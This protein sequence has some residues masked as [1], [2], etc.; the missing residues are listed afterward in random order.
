MVRSVGKNVVERSGPR[1][2]DVDTKG[3]AHQERSPPR[4]AATAIG[5]R[6]VVRGAA[7]RRTAR[8][9][10]D[11][12]KTAHQLLRLSQA[13]TGVSPRSTDGES[14]SDWRLHDLRRT[15]RTNLS[16]LGVQPNVAELMIGHE[17]R[18]ILAIYDR[19]A[20]ETEQ[21]AGFEAWCRR[22]TTI[23]GG[24][25]YWRHGRQDTRARH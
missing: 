17:Q 22:L 4:R 6:D 19:H 8:V 16:V 2:G 21:R 12:W 25:Q 13:S 18:G 11:A 3:R 1:K 23:V 14:I 15:M 20:Y 5:G 10:H 24:P 7:V 9:L